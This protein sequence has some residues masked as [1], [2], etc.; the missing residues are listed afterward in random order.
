MFKQNIELLQNI[1]KLSTNGA[2][3]NKYIHTKN[4]I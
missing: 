2:N 1:T 4:S 3:L